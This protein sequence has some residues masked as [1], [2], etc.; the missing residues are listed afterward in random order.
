MDDFVFEVRIWPLSGFAH[1]AA[2]IASDELAGADLLIL[3]IE[4]L[5]RF[6]EAMPDHLC[7]M[8]QQMRFGR[9]AVA[10]LTTDN[11]LMGPGSLDFL[12]TAA[13]QAG[14]DFIFP[15]ADLPHGY[16]RGDCILPEDVDLQPVD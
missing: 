9:A 3:S 13:K 2:K 7:A 15:R 10:I 4:H 1:A 6:N 14:V 8:F 5:D 11:D 16:Q 12:Q